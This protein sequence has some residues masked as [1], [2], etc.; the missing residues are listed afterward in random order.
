MKLQLNGAAS[1]LALLSLLVGFAAGAQEQL[2]DNM[3]ILR[4]KVAADKK[5]IIAENL[6]LTESQAAQFW[7]IYDAYQK[8][9][10][11]LNERIGALV[12]NYATAYN[13]GNVQ[14][15][16]ANELVE[17]F[18]A[19]EEAQL[20]LRKKYADRLDGVIPAVERARYLQ[21]EQKIRAL[22]DYD[23]AANIPLVD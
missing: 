3:D 2:S 12:E 11:A 8:D 1:A 6:I 18:L 4:E 10:A 16:K 17:E 19:I 7:P 13:A 23:M 22:I 5:L 9:L 20:D 21:M 15:A 14:E